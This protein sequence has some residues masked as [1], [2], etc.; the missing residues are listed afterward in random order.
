MDVAGHHKHMNES[1]FI[2]DTH[3]NHANIIEYCKRPFQDVAHMNRVM[4]DQ[5]RDLVHEGDVV[6][7]LGDFGF[8]PWHTIEAILPQL[9]GLLCL[10]T[11][12]HDRGRENRFRRAG[13]AVARH[14]HVKL[15]NRWVLARHKFDPEYD[16]WQLCGHVHRWFRKHPSK[17]VINVG[18]DVWNFEPV[19][20][21]TLASMIERGG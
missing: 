7:H 3:F 5:W 16:G 2:S 20:E 15:A 17:K 13:V 6:Y 12:N 11:G 4:I 9:P 8:G 21:E 19:C 18:V 1:W 14:V 10:I